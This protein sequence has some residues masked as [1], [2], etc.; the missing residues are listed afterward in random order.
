MAK[1]T[2]NIGTSANSRTGDPLRTS[3]TKINSNFTELYDRSE[4]SGSYSDLTNKPT[5]PADLSDLTDTEGLHV[6]QAYA[7]LTNNPIIVAEV[8][9]DE[10][11][12]FTKTDNG[13]EVD[14]IA[15]GLSIT[16]GANRGIYNIAQELEY[17]RDNYT[18]PA[19]TK[20]NADGWTNLSNVL[21]RGY[22]YWANAHDFNPSE[23]VEN[24]TEFLMHDEIN[25]EYYAI[26][27]LSWTEN[28][29][30]GG[31]SYSRRKLIIP[32]KFRKTDGG[33]EVDII[34]DGL[35]LTRGNQGYLYNPAA[36][37][38]G[39]ENTSPANTLWNDGGW[40][41]LNNIPTRTYVPFGEAFGN[42]LRNLPQRRVVMKDTLNNEYYLIKFLSW[43]NGQNGG[44][45]SYVRY[46][47][48]Q[49]KLPEGVL[50]ADGTSQ[51]T[52]YD[53]S[54][55][56]SKYTN[57]Q[58]GNE[59]RIE[60]WNS[61]SYVELADGERFTLNAVTSINSNQGPGWDIVIDKASNPDIEAAIVAGN[62]EWDVTINGE[63]Y[64]TYGYT[65]ESYIVFYITSSEQISYLQGDAIE[66]SYTVGG[67]PVMWWN[68]D[69]APS[70]SKDFRGA[71]INYH[72]YV[73][74]GDGGTIIGQINFARDSGSRTLS[75]SESYSGSFGLQD[76]QPWINVTSD[77]QTVYVSRTSL[78]SCNITF[79][80]TSTLFYG[81]DYW[82]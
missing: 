43:T 78:Q 38:E 47:I 55:P 22:T 12:I 70:G 4:F 75:H 10:E 9:L 68:V 80:W 52:A 56:L 30:G 48:D 53:P 28:D 11:V 46:K 45:F 34:D 54:K 50:F 14:E 7:Q 24:E 19:G 40:G 60:Q 6:I 64:E 23:A 42:Y 82:D 69:K 66:A 63:T 1:Q 51:R 72:A 25:D 39:P 61:G 71:I 31:F 59:W 5:I 2:I 36:G 32:F 76:V 26:K 18:S 74:N 81:S 77:S 3:F 17:D 73:S 58:S 49:T 79:H 44:G 29:N 16:R 33:S 27:F 13:S 67:D 8:T 41:E 37:E 21:D 57:P 15:E 20:W 65:T 62:D 35:S